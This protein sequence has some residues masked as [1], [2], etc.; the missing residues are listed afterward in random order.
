MKDQLVTYE[1]AKELESLG[2]NESCLF[3]FEPGYGGL[4]CKLNPFLKRNSTC[5]IGEITAPLW[6][7][8]IDWFREKYDLHIEVNSWYNPG[9][10]DYDNSI[11]YEYYIS[12]KANLFDGGF[13]NA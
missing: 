10:S 1:I 6:Q 11:Y 3:S 13:N 2:F 5:D 12:C 7:Q 4:E 8:V 9:N